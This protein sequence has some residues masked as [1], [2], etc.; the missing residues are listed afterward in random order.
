MGC[1]DQPKC[2]SSFSKWEIQEACAF[3]VRLGILERPRGKRAA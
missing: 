1:P 3:L 2:L